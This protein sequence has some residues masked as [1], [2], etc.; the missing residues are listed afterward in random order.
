MDMAPPIPPEQL[1]ILA[2]ESQGPKTVS[3]VIAFTALALVFVLLRLF[4][5]I[6]FTQLVGWEDCFITVS[7]LFSVAQAA[8]QIKQVG[9]GAGKHQV[10]VDLPSTIN[11]LKYLYWSILTYCVGFT[12]TK[13]S[14]LTQ[15]R[16]IFAVKRARIPIYIVMGL[17]VATGTEAL[18]TFA[19]VCTPVDAFWNVMKRPAAKCLDEDVLRYINGTLNMVTDLLIA[20]LPIRVIWRLQLVRRQKIALI[21]LLTLGWFVSIVSIIRLHSL[22]VLS[23]NPQDSMFYAAPPIYWAAIEMN[24]AIVCACVPA[25][26]PLVVQVIPAFASRPSENNSSQ[27]SGASRSSKLSRSFL[28]LD[29]NDRSFEGSVDA[30]QGSAGSELR[31]I[32]ALPP[33]H[34]RESFTRHVRGTQ[35]MA[36][37]QY[38]GQSRGT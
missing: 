38:S 22:Y 33:V 12:F 11:S 21:A 31:P 24:L 2:S 36:T 10:L 15:Y 1:A 17:C 32:T 23:Q 25:L 3:I 37:K 26:K 14:I 5:R 18:F 29:G 20:A 8:L 7:M 6:R 30:E 28:K 19:F 16:R 35:N 13:V 9:W 27:R 4:V 34:Q